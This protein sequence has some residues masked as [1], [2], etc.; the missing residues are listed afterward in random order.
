MNRLEAL[1]Y[2]AANPEV[3]KI[4]KPGWH[5]DWF[6]YLTLDGQMCANDGL[7]A[8]L[9]AEKHFEIYSP[10]P[11]ILSDE[12]WVESIRYHPNFGLLMCTR[13]RE[14]VREEM[15]KGK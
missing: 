9:G 5:P 6:I 4:T 7:P 15:E 12:E 10:K 13:I 8:K 2:L 11:K 1:K 14:I 3:N